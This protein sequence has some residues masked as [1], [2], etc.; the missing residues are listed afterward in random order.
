MHRVIKILE[1]N[2]FFFFLDRR[3]Y[4]I[5]NEEQSI[6]YIEL[7]GTA[8]VGQIRSKLIGST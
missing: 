1:I 5:D 6:I 3:G 2:Q 4:I 7:Y 8:R